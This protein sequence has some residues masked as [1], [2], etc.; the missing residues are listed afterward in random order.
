MPERSSRSR[1]PSRRAQ[2]ALKA[3]NLPTPPNTR[4][5]GRSSSLS[6][7]KQAAATSARRGRARGGIGCVPIEHTPT[8]ASSQP[9][10]AQQTRATPT[11][12][13]PPS[14]PP[15]IDSP[16]RSVES[17]EVPEVLE[18]TAEREL[19]AFDFDVRIHI[20]L[21]G[22]KN[23]TLTQRLRDLK[24]FAALSEHRSRLQKD[25]KNHR[26]FLP[27]GPYTGR[28]FLGNAGKHINTL[29]DDSGLIDDESDSW[30]GFL[31]PF[32]RKALALEKARKAGAGEIVMDLE[33][34]VRSEK[35]VEVSED[36]SNSSAMSDSEA[37][38]DT[39]QTRRKRTAQSGKRKRKGRET[40]TQKMRRENRH[41]REAE[42]LTNQHMRKIRDAHRC[43]AQNCKNHGIYACIDTGIPGSFRGFAPGHIN[44]NNHWLKRWNT[45]IGDGKATVTEVPIGILDEA[46][47]ERYRE[48]AA[49]RKSTQPTAQLDAAPRV[50]YF[51]GPVAHA[52]ANEAQAAA[53]SAVAPRSSPPQLTGDEDHNVL[54]YMQWL[55]QKNP[56]S[57]AEF[58]RFAGVLAEHGWGFSDL[59]DVTEKDWEAMSI[60]AGFR[61]RIIKELKTF[62]RAQSACE[63]VG[64]EEEVNLIL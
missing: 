40:S 39:T 16:Q 62:A 8:P 42:A 47:S 37:G 17:V 21:N 55:G 10:S 1:T 23:V 51:Y 56:M 22:K 19:A 25:L 24:V 60:P 52:G 61:R 29:F 44:L 41:D 7:R 49:A 34:P 11:P 26:V 64:G 30:Y 48:I 36:D 9:Q 4:N 2:E 38:L 6:I 45:L 13:P 27:P 35:V 53:A 33:V 32:R 58:E 20:L 28:L 57:R 14:S 43:S 63:R 15:D 50:Q 18:A 31:L 54:A 59:R 12:S 46:M 3:S 5:K